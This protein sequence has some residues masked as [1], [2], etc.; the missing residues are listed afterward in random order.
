MG[1]D[2]LNGGLGNDIL[3]GG[4]GN[5]TLIG[6]LGQDLFT[7]DINTIFAMTIGQDTI[8]DFD[9]A[10]DKIVLDKTTFTA[11]SS[12][13]GNVFSQISQFAVVSNDTAAQTSGALITYNNTNGNLFYNQNGAASGLGSGGLFAHLNKNPTLSASNFLLVA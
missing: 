12:V 8:T 1:N 4:F 10:N 3:V 9:T 11:F 5:D 13:V 7:F 6:G 2:I